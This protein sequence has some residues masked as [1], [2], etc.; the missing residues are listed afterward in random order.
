MKVGVIIPNAG[1]EPSVLGIQRMAVEAE[2]AGAQSL[3]VS[4]HLVFIDR[5]NHDYPF[6]ADGV[7]SWDMTADYYE[8]LTCCAAMAS[9][10]ERA[11]IGTAVLVLPQ[12]NAFEVAKTAATVD[13]LSGGRFELGVGAGWNRDESDTDAEE[14]GAAI[15]GGTRASRPTPR[16][17]PG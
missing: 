2:N 13:R 9:A 1:E 4:D 7:P 17:P 12:R 6:S 8:A 16:R 14:R 10:T 5:P 11:R 15:G 3:W